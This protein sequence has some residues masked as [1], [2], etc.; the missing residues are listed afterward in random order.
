MRDGLIV[1]PIDEETYG[2]FAY[3]SP[4]EGLA[5][6]DI[7]NSTRDTVMAGSGDYAVV[8]SRDEV[9]VF[10]VVDGEYVATFPLDFGDADVSS[11]CLS[12]DQEYVAVV[13]SNGLAIVGDTSSGRVIDLTQAANSKRPAIR[14]VAWTSADQL[15]YVTEL[16]DE[17]A[18]EAFDVIT[19]GR[20]RIAA[21]EG[22]RA[23]WLTSGAAM[24]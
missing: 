20:H 1:K 19:R 2:R 18:V 12:P 8:V 3:W 7:A 6:L 11:V 23:W 9:G 5:P 22:S 17:I 24:C 4:T 16:R 14:S 15:V 10:N 21:L 13:A